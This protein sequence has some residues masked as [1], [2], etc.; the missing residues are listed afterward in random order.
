MR[1]RVILAIVALLAV[2]AGLAD[3]KGKAS[4][5]L[6]VPKRVPAVGETQNGAQT[7]SMDLHMTIGAQKMDMK[8]TSERIEDLEILDVKDGVVTKEKI[9]YQKRTETTT[10]AGSTNQGVDLAGKVYVVEWTGSELK[11]TAADGS[12][13]P[14]DE[15]DKVKRDAGTV[16]KPD[17]FASLLTGPTFQT[18][19]T[20]TVSGDDLA[21][22]FAGDDKLKGGNASL[23][24]KTIE[25]GHATIALELTMA[26]SE[27]GFSMSFGIHGLIT[28][29]TSTGFVSA[30]EIEGPITIDGQAKGDG[31]LKLAGTASFKKP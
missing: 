13:P 1:A 12:T 9:A 6:K 29:E 22:L 4:K 24:L 5:G 25:N 20:V 19:K 17:T 27:S 10:G 16:G 30:F 23:T 26:M 31:F 8:M 21:K 7:M 3:A 15:L 14:A 11:I 18:G 2:T 28:V